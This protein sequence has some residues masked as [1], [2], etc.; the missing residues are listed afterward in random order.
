MNDTS[1]IPAAEKTTAEE[2][3]VDAALLKQLSAAA[4]VAA[5]WA[6]IPRPAAPSSF[7]KRVEAARQALRE[8]ESCLAREPL[9]PPVSDQAIAARRSALLELGASHRMFRSA[10]A[11]VSDKPRAIARLPRLLLAPAKDEPR[12][13]AVAR[14][15]LDAVEGAFS[16]ITLQAFVQDIQ[17]H[18]PLNVDEL[19]SLGAFLRFVMLELLLEQS[20]A[21]FQDS[22]A[23]AAPLLV[24]HIKCMRAITHADWVFLIEPLIAFD[25]ILAQDPAGVYPAMD[26]ESRELYRR[27]IAE[28]AS[29]SNLTE[30]QV[31]QA[32]LD[33]A[34][35][36]LKSR[37]RE[38]AT[39]AQDRACRL[40][41]DRSWIPPAR[42]SRP[43][44][45]FARMARAPVCSSPC[46]GFFPQRRRALHLPLHRCRAVS[47]SSAN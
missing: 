31:A 43:I 2:T 20:R 34:R 32:A 41:P 24:D 27:R 25:R 23:G 44:P 9:P 22:G 17:A 1:T 47:S 12:V 30:V 18:E 10:I 26:F 16:A 37:N 14:L 45:S 19:W 28:I 33:L 38:S 29:R 46:A 5:A 40:L 42:G 6:F 7:P 4:D 15:Y 21:L 36:A 13:A 35:K 3:T 8:L 39:A 11:A